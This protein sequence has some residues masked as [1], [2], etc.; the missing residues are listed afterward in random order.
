M[1]YATSRR[2]QLFTTWE[3]LITTDDARRRRSSAAA[4]AAALGGVRARHVPQGPRQSDRDRGWRVVCAGAPVQR[5][6]RRGVVAG[7]RLLGGERSREGVSRE[8]VDVVRGG[9][10]RRARGRARSRLQQPHGR[11]SHPPRRP[12]R[13]AGAVPQRQRAVGHAPG[14]VLRRAGA[15]RARRGWERAFG[16]RARGVVRAARLEHPRDGLHRRLRHAAARAGLGP[17]R[18]HR[19]QRRW[20]QPVGNAE[21]CDVV[22]HARPPGAGAGVQRA[23]GHGPVPLGAAQAFCPV[24]HRQR[25]RRAALALFGPA[26]AASAARRQQPPQGRASRAVVRHGRAGEPLRR[27]Q[28]AFGHAAAPLFWPW[29]A[30]RVFPGTTTFRANFATPAACRTW[31]ASCWAATA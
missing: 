29:R 3:Q 1:L 4:A 22:G 26:L 5:H 12:W 28:H 14:R 13:A 25:A 6:G 2:E 19:L 18:A 21:R 7:L 30:H 9:V 15:F 20:V 16:D 24:P 11:R 10:R 8:R 31:A 27:R 17:L 23:V